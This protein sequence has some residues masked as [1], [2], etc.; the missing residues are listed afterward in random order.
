MS[1]RRLPVISG[2]GLIRKLSQAY[3]YEIVRQKGSHIRIR[4]YL[5][6]KHSLTTP[7]HKELDRGT[8]SGIIDE[9]A[10]HFG[11]E[12]EDVVRSLFD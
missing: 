12:K 6:G 11:T 7:D 4:T 8:L 2:R 3:G 9:V 1:P 5:G 10:R